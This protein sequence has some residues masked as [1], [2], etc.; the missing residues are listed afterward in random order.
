MPVMLPTDDSRFPEG[1]SLYR[2]YFDAAAQRALLADIQA[3]VVAAPWFQPVMPG[4]GK[5]FSVHMTN[6]GALGWVS[7]QS[8]GYRYQE[9]HPATGA[10][11]PP[12][13]S[14]ILDL[15]CAVTSYPMPPQCCLVNLYGHQKARMGMHI[16]GDETARDAPVVSVS[17]G[18]PARFR[19]GGHAR[20]DPS[21]SMRLESGDVVVL[22]GSSRHRYH[23]IDRI[24]YGHNDLIQ[25]FMGTKGRLNLTL[26]RVTPPE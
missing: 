23:G 20:R 22:G 15:W 21:F 12:I 1:F 25:D 16:D 2:G 3:V 5:P 24:D 6:A 17:L 11:W 9:T 8:G 19:L 13:P 14:C 7:D 4:T 26:R 18:D 10:S